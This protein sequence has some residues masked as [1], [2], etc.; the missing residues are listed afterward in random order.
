MIIII[1]MPFKIFLIIFFTF[2]THCAY[3]TDIE[4]TNFD[5]LINS[6]PQSG[7]TITFGNNL[8]SSSSIA[9]HFE[10]LNITFDGNNFYIDGSDTFGGFILNRE[11]NFNSVRIIN[12]K[13]QEYNNS[14]YA[15]AIY[16]EGGTSSIFNADFDGN[17]VDT[18]GVN[19]A[20]GGAV[21]NLLGGNMKIDTALFY[22][23]Y[24]NAADAYGGALANGYQNDTDAI[25][26]ITKSVFENNHSEGSVLSYGG[27]FYNAGSANITSS[28]FE[29]NYADSTNGFF[30]YG[31]AIYNVGKMNIDNSLINSNHVDGENSFAAAGGAIYNNSALSIT[32]SI[33]KDNHAS[34]DNGATGGAI[35]NDTGGMLTIKNSTLQDNYLQSQDA[36]G[37]AIGNRGTLII[38]SSTFKN[39]REN[40][41]TNDIY[42][43]NGTIRFQG[44]GT[45]EILGGIKGNGEIYKED[46]GV[47]NLGGNN[48]DYTGNFTFNG[49]TINLLADSVYFGAQDN[50]FGNNVNFNMQN[51]QIDNV[52]F[53][54]LTLSGRTNIYPDVNFNTNLMDTIS[55]SLLEGSG[56]IYVPR[57]LISGTPE[58]Q[59]ISIPFANTTLKNSISYTPK[60]INTPIYN[61][62]SSYNSQNGHFDFTRGGFY[63]GV[64][65]G[66]VATQIAGYL[67]TID[68]FYNVFSN[69]D[70]VLIGDKYKA[71]SLKFK[72]R[73]ASIGTNPLFSPNNIPEQNAGVWF[74]PYSIFENVPLKNGPEVSNVQYGTMFGAESELKRLKN[75]FFGLF[76]TYGVYKGSH[77]AYDGIGI[78]NNGG[79]FG[80]NGA[81]YKGGYFTLISANVGANTSRAYTD[82]GH[83]N[84]AMLNTGISQ[85]TGYNFSFFNNKLI[86]QPSIMTSY[87]FVNT[88][89]YKNASGLDINTHPLNAIHIEPQIKLIGNFKNY[90]QPYLSVSFAWNIIDKTKFKVNDIYLS[91][92]SVKPYVKYGAGIQKRFGERLTGFFEAMIRNGG[93]NG[94]GL[95][96]G[97]RFSI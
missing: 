34:S 80:L 1:I 6:T 64:L 49:G 65:A 57:L 55:A 51:R 48:S 28:V 87:V 9:A 76:G 89:D 69:L 26:E 47:L 66:E 8:T 90:I 88:F 4:V 35:F 7:D 58:G 45:T 97:L 62:N 63:P 16:N 50:T 92:L 44:E 42:N 27:A 39:N 30:G 61:Y 93:R 46:S 37:G 17:F 31:G 10:N 94:V 82:F 67:G 60:I 84:F 78:N 56:N 15:G 73:Y 59:F 14:Y 52:N 81:I 68:T 70:M 29:N 95:Q 11:N 43:E 20:V 5:E 40:E 91:D 21:Y 96:L 3:C 38:L 19:F 23:N 22:D 41:N 75:G 36:R 72:D 53:N 86:L 77:L 2:F 13:G 79:L 25:I 12:C 24:A 71:A 54:D 33:L 32:N 85:K 18:Q 83:E 74:K